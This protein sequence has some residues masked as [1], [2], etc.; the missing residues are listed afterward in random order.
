MI[1]TVPI[2]IRQPKVR[3]EENDKETVDLPA[4]NRSRAPIE[5]THADRTGSARSAGPDD[6]RR[7]AFGCD[8]GSTEEI[9]RLLRVSR[10]SQKDGASRSRTNRPKGIRSDHKREDPRYNA[11]KSPAGGQRRQTPSGDVQR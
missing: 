4:S 11:P 8:R 2:R 6:R 5:P 1:Q 10:N 9:E 7:N 3:R